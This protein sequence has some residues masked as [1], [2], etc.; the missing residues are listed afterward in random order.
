MEVAVDQIAE[1]PSLP[2]GFRGAIACRRGADALTL[3]GFSADRADEVLI[4]TFVS[5]L[6]ADLPESLSDATVSALDERHWRIASESRDWIVAATSL[7]VH[8]D[9]G[10]AFYRAIPPRPT[11]LA[12][13]LLWRAVMALAASRAGKRLLLSLR[14][15]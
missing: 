7:H 14:G 6:P 1:T 2:A 5:P 4:L 8:R 10:K 15:R 3:S 12:K 13:R 9:I 11:P